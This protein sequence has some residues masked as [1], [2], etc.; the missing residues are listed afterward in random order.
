[1][2]RDIISLGLSIYPIGLLVCF[3]TAWFFNKKFY[4]QELAKIGYIE[5]LLSVEK[6]LKN[7]KEV[8]RKEV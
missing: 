3:T 8:I 1:M 2:G 7:F 4:Y 5:R 6:K